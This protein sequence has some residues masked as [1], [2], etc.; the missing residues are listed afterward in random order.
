[1]DYHNSEET[2]YPS[3]ILRGDG[4]IASY[5]VQTDG[6]ISHTA[7]VTD[8]QSIPNLWNEEIDTFLAEYRPKSPVKTTHGEDYTQP[9]TSTISPTQDP[10]QTAGGTLHRGVGVYVTPLPELRVEEIDT[11][12]TGYH[13]KTLGKA[14]PNED[15]IP[16][17]TSSISP[18]QDPISKLNGG[19]A[20]SYKV[21]A[22]DEISHNTVP[23]D[24]RALSELRI[25]ELDSFLTE[26]APKTAVKVNH[27]ATSA[28]TFTSSISQ[29]QNPGPIS[30]R[31]GRRVVSYKVQNVGDI[32]HNDPGVNVQTIPDLLVEEMETFLTEYRPKIPGK[33]YRGEDYLPLFI[34]SVCRK[35]YYEVENFV[36]HQNKHLAGFDCPVCHIPQPNAEV[37]DVHLRWQHPEKTQPTTTP[38]NTNTVFRCY[39]IPA[40]PSRSMFHPPELNGVK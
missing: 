37:R 38:F 18:K 19:C 14:N 24:A 23:D 10:V 33:I 1:M 7:T 27:E 21:E 17:F 25:E 35:D 8:V 26:F 12:L 3:S 39:T 5:K 13:P 32:T 16:P 15:Y 40:I 31:S 28:P 29:Q 2:Q 34:C 30:N 20:G 11:F 9:F 6:D 22:V 36:N 4:C